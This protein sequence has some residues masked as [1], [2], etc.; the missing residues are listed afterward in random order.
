MQVDGVQCSALVGSRCSQSIVSTNQCMAWSSQQVDMWTIDRTS[1][2]CCG[3]GSVS[4]LTNGGGHAIVNVL[5]A[6]ERPL[7]YNLLIR[8]DM[9]RALG[10]IT[11]TPAGDMKL[12]G[13]KEACAALCVNEPDFNASFKY[14]KRI[15]TARWK[16]TL[17]NA[18]TLLHNQIAEYKIPDNIRGEYKRELQVM[19]A[20]SWLI[21][22]PQE[23]LGPSKGL[24]PLMAIVQHTKGKGHTVMD[25]REL[26]EHV[27]AFTAD[28]FT[29]K[30]RE[31][32]Q[33]GVHVALLDLW[34]V[35]VWVHKSLWAY[36]MVLIK[37]E[38]Y[39]LT[40]LGFGLNVALMIMKV[41]VSTVLVQEEQT[42]KMMSSY[43]DDIY[44]NEEV[45]SA[46]KVKV[47]LKS[48]GLTCKDPECLKHGAK[49]LGLKVW[50]EHDTLHWKWGT[51][52][53]EPPAE[54]TLHTAFS[55]CGKL[56]GH[57]SVCGWLRMIASSKKMR[58]CDDQGME[59]PGRQCLPQA[60][61]GRSAGEGD[62]WWPC[63][64]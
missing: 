15:W 18:P 42:M 45:I 10:G 51:A 4:I 60:S 9:I 19:I 56:M 13:G 47:K 61:R 3:V 34:R 49:V 62:P 31:W 6:C 58:D 52:I 27:D 5:V 30:L 29:A 35:Y 20:N 63:P 44:V 26:N 2:V 54:M 22:L 21:P 17:N 43:S 25:Y 11:I 33:Q 57:F 48:F 12:G 37:G 64:R 38:R 39:C 36:Q 41:I 50:R 55:M 46:D 24:I 7:S 59:W 40:R 14:K 28:V 23:W 16:W 1:W 8:I 53:P 32:H